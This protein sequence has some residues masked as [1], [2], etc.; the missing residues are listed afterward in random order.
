MARDYEYGSIALLYDHRNSGAGNHHRLWLSGHAISTT[1]ECRNAKRFT[2][3]RN[4]GNA[5][6]DNGSQHR[7]HT[8]SRKIGGAPADNAAGDDNTGTTAGTENN[9]RA[10]ASATAENE[11]AGTENNC[12]TAAA[13]TAACAEEDDTAGQTRLFSAD[14]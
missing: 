6:T 13:T 8:S 14:E 11:S 12:R 4:P 2:G 5:D 10:T 9:G 3:G 7:N 1:Q